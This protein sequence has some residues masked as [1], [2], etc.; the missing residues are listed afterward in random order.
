MDGGAS[1]TTTVLGDSG[2]LL[3]ALV[4]YW[5]LWI[6]RFALG[7]SCVHSLCFCPFSWVAKKLYI[8]AMFW[9]TICEIFKL[10]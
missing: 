7:N 2:S 1:K 8:F 5:W 3:V 9:P 4:H 10:E 6:T